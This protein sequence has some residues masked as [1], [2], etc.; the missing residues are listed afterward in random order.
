[1]IYF[2]AL[3]AQFLAVMIVITFHEFAHAY[4]AYKCGDPTAKFSGRMTLNPVKHFD[5][6]GILMFAVAGFGW[7][8]PV[9]INP[10][11]FNDYKKGSFWTSSAGVLMNYAMAFVF[12]PV[13]ILTF[14]YVLPIF[15]GKLIAD[16]LYVFT[17]ALFTCSLSFCVF[18]LL[19]FYPLDGFR[20]VDAVSKRRSKAYWFLK[21]YGYYILM[22]LILVHVL[23][24][25]VPLLGVID[26]L[27]YI[28]DFAIKVFGRPITM[29]WDWIL[30]FIL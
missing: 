24:S 12:Y 2:V 20:I 11:N 10:Y 27:G 7:A 17:N 13:F 25:R 30:R 21:Q 15:S 9:P 8:K 18:N 1:M 26:L 5:P 19:P 6:L 23:S 28:L 3:L 29:F 4:T 16:F 22:G 14:Y